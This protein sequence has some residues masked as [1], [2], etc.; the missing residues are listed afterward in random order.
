MPFLPGEIISNSLWKSFWWADNAQVNWNQHIATS[1]RLLIATPV[2]Q[3]RSGLIWKRS[4]RLDQKYQ[5][6]VK[7]ADDVHMVLGGIVAPTAY[8]YIC[9][10]TNLFKK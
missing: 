1:A 4:F 6:Y 7:P 10:F 8:F 2:L 9:C 5:T 3:I